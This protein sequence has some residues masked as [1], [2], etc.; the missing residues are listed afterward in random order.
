MTLLKNINE[1][2]INVSNYKEDSIYNQSILS[3]EVV[4]FIMKSAHFEELVR[5]KSYENIVMH[6]A[7]AFYAQNKFI[8]QHSE[9]NL[10]DFI[11][12]HG[13]QSYKISASFESMAGMFFVYMYEFFIYNA[14]HFFDKYKEERYNKLIRD[15]FFVPS[16]KHYQ[17]YAKK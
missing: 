11:E 10:M 3:H 2:Y 6:E 14:I 4:H 17:D 9:Y 15:E 13:D 1:V 8:E 7:F 12:Q 5:S 16:F